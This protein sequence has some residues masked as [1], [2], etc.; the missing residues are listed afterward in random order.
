M[1]N[2]AL[3]TCRVFRNTVYVLCSLGL[4]TGIANSQTRVHRAVG[5]AQ[6]GPNDRCGTPVWTING[7]PDGPDTRGTF[8]GLEDLSNDATGAEDIT[9]ADCDPQSAD[10]GRLVATTYDDSFG[11]FRGW[12]APNVVLENFPLRDI[13]IPIG[14]GVYAPIPLPGGVPPNPFPPT[15]VEPTTPISIGAW[16]AADGDLEII[17]D[18]GDNTA[19]VAARMTN[20]VPNGVYTMWGQWWD[21]AEELIVTPFGGY[22]NTLVADPQ[23]S[24]EFCRDI[25]YCPIDLTP[26][27]S[28]LQF[29][30][31][32]YMGNGATFGAVPYESTTTRA[33]VGVLSL[34]FLSTIPGGIVSFDHIAFRVNSVGGPD[35]GPTSPMMCTGP[36]LAVPNSAPFV[37]G[38]AFVFLAIGTT[39]LTRNRLAAAS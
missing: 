9:P 15:I 30:S 14:N 24:I 31:A 21:P 17:C 12:T 34:P 26:D 5:V 4:V 39:A 11:T 3:P 23:G 2:S 33:F 7:L 20:L 6:T 10:L 19:T 8:L 13:P 36:A 16:I 37:I 28:E 18:D 22:P 1:W 35:P 32:V 29:I 38:L 27:G 25:H